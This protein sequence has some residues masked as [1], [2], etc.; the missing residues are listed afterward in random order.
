MSL[1]L[2]LQKTQAA[3]TGSL[4]ATETGSDSAAINGKVLIQGSLAT[5]ET[6]SD[7]ASISGNVLVSGSLSATE[8][9]SD[10]AVINGN[11][12]VSGSLSATES[13]QDTASFNGFVSGGDITGSLAATETGTDTASIS[14]KVFVSGSLAATESGQDAA[15]INGKIIVSGSLS[16]QETGQDTA[17]FASSKNVTVQITGISLEISQAQLTF[18]QGQNAGRTQTRRR[19][20]GAYFLQPGL[21]AGIPIIVEVNGKAKVKE[22]FAVSSCGEITTSATFNVVATV[23]PIDALST[24][25]DIVA[26]SFTN[27]TDEELIYLLAA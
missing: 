9:G 24:Q 2:L 8:S 11:V 18:Q 22:V 26:R 10:T 5:T 21:V 17:E 7:T 25:S 1:L 4:A 20:K 14:G 19:K 3:I 27:P 16:A 23:Y 12:L 15:E 13:G 6:G